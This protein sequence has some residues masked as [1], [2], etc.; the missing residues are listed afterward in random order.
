MAAQPSKIYTVYSNTVNDRFVNSA[1]TK[2]LTLNCKTSLFLKR[3]QSLK[4]KK[5]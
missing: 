5:F 4:I 1:T 3:F 2:K